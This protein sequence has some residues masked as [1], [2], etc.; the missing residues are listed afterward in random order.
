MKRKLAGPKGT[1]LQRS[2]ALG[3]S[4]AR[5]LG[6][7]LYREK[8]LLALPILLLSSGTFLYGQQHAAEL[9]EFN[10]TMVGD[11][12]IVTPAVVRQNNPQFMAVT[13]A[14]RQGDAAF[15]NVEEPY[16]LT[17]KA[18]PA[19][20]PR[21]HWHTADPSMLKQ[22]QW[23]GFNL[24]GV[25]NNHS[26][27]FG[28]QGLL[29][30]IQVLKQDG[31]VYA[32]IGKNLGQARAPAYLSTPHGRV[33]LIT[34]ASTFPEDSAAGQSRT[35]MEGRPGLN[36]LH[37][38]TTFRVD[39]ATFEAQRRM[40]RDLYLRGTENQ[41]GGSPQVT[42]PFDGVPLTFEVSDKPA[43]V[44]TPDPKDLAALTHSIRDARE[45]ADYV[46]A[47][48]HAHEG[49][50]GPNPLETPAQFLVEYAHAAIDAGADV[51]VGS[52]PHVLRGIE[53]YKGKVILYSLGNFIFENWLM[54]PQPEDFYERYGV[55]QDALPSE[56]YAARSDHGRRD[57]PANPIYWDTAVARVT[58][59]DGRPAVVTLTPAIT[60]FGKR[61]PDQGYPEA[62]DPAT[63]TRIL[64]H[65]RKLSEPFGTKITISNGVGTITIPR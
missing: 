12:E 47:S 26:M 58:F 4:W 65:W 31:A 57:E 56:A 35:D 8:F 17:D 13:N 28:I 33:A 20:Q 2:L 53:I 19:G 45:M 30:T 49:A 23:M 42:I 62:P 50:P 9:P 39:A 41:S 61:A 18:Y 22:L 3:I 59:R 6:G 54:V 7:A 40:N 46:V 15:T 5:S 64:E 34:C 63:A 32:G 36:P 1:L 25:A 16:P 44:T 43:V 29:E 27:D 11:S 38:K 14:V 10:L 48:I 52:G 55:G 60:G 21:S 51:F 37:H 24:F